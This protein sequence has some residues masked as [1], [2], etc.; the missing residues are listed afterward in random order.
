[1]NAPASNPYVLHSSSPTRLRRPPGG[2]ASMN[3]IIM[4]IKSIKTVT[5]APACHL[6]VTNFTLFNAL[7]VNQHHSSLFTVKILICGALAAPI[8]THFNAF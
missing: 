7:N 6:E 2:H 1:M 4:P 5:S 8:L 3:S